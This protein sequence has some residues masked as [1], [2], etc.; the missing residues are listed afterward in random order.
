MKKIIFVIILLSIIHISSFQ[1]NRG[2]DN[3]IPENYSEN[4]SEINKNKNR[5]LNDAHKTKFNVENQ[6][7]EELKTKSSGYWGLF[8]ALF[9]I[10]I[11]LSILYVYFDVINE[12]I[13]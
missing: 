6:N 11:I 12:K 4:N 9:I 5:S 8:L 2:K 10:S 7:T 1:E 13:C 3:N